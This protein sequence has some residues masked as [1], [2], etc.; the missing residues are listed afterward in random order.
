LKYREIGIS[1]YCII[2]KNTKNTT[3]QLSK[4]NKQIRHKHTVDIRHKNKAMKQ[5]WQQ[6]KTEYFADLYF[7]KHSTKPNDSEL[8]EY[9]NQHEAED[10][11]PH[12]LDIENALYD[13]L[14]QIAIQ[15]QT[16]TPQRAAEIITSAEF[17]V[18]KDI[19][20]MLNN[21]TT[22]EPVNEQPE[23]VIEQTP[24][25][26]EEQTEQENT[27][28]TMS[29]IT[30][31][32]KQ[33]GFNIQ[34]KPKDLPI[35]DNNYYTWATLPN[36][37]KKYKPAPVTKDIISMIAPF[38]SND[39][40]RPALTGIYHDAEAQAMVATNSL[41][42]VYH[43]TK[44]A[45]E[46]ENKIIGIK[47]EVINAQ[48]PLYKSLVDE[49]FITDSYSYEIDIRILKTFVTAISQMLDKKDFFVKVAISKRYAV[50]DIDCLL[51]VINYWEQQKETKLFVYHKGNDSGMFVFA[52]QKLKTVE[53]LFDNSWVIIMPHIAETDHFQF[54]N[55]FA[56]IRSYFDFVSNSIV[57]SDKNDNFY[58]EKYIAAETDKQHNITIKQIKALKKL[59]PKKPTLPIIEEVYVDGNG[60]LA[61]TD[62]TT[63]TVITK[64]GF[65]R[66][67]YGFGADAL[68]STYSDANDFTQTGFGD[69]T[70]IAEITDTD[71]TAK[72]EDVSKNI[73]KENYTNYDKIILVAEKGS[74]ITILATN[75]D[76]FTI[77]KI[78]A[79][80][81]EDDNIYIE[82]STNVTT[83][84]KNFDAG[85]NIAIR[86][87]NRRV[88]LSC[89]AFEI[90]TPYYSFANNRNVVYRYRNSL[91]PTIK[92]SFDSTKLIETAK[93]HKADGKNAYDIRLFEYLS[94][95]ITNDDLYVF[96]T[97][98]DKPD[99]LIIIPIKTGTNV[100]FEDN[101]GYFLLSFT[102]SK[103]ENILNLPKGDIDLILDQNLNCA[104]I[105]PTK[106]IFGKKA[107]K[108][109]VE[110]IEPEPVAPEPTPEPDTTLFEKK[111]KR[112]K[113]EAKQE[114][115]P[116]PELTA[117][118]R[119][120]KKAAEIKARKAKEAA[121]AEAK[122]KQEPT[123][124][125]E[126]TAIE[127]LYKKA[128]EIKARKA[129]EATEAEAKA[130]Q[131]PTP[132]R[133]L[134]AIERLYKKAAEIKA[135]KAKEATQAPK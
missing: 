130:K 20:E 15:K 43:K 135:R 108:P 40:R 68:I 32:G 12:Y 102:K 5:L 45:K 57:S 49:N 64:T 48:F 16:M 97:D 53:Q 95:R 88:C 90:Y 78:K 82:G 56:Y 23:N 9:I 89:A 63:Y 60:N 14:Y 98:N 100:D 62:L 70:L 99:P 115:T 47:G 126:L 4:H 35:G 24:E 84:L 94:I 22:E 28:T 19:L 27:T 73:G 85:G 7:A 44:I 77:R 91:N 113:A 93:K 37:L 50:F 117:I 1:A 30:I 122:A 61:I 26:I 8:V 13:S 11:T 10:V 125:P 46:N 74:Q 92:I 75:G 128:A 127:R 51:S 110:D 54:V 67:M 101:D 87:D 29:H 81:Y 106:K 71:F 83:V 132:E 52:A 104:F 114:P 111:N 6:T 2:A 66:G 116:E 134:T 79:K 18:P 112:K 59:K 72:F 33:S 25:P 65:E 17:D 120:Y 129:K 76:S 96:S 42:L 80:V 118:E 107:V 131:E 123:P 55:S 86:K 105:R 41:I 124:E 58:H 121:E 109:I 3:K 133:E 39:E 34:K 38:V 31:S 103:T 119:L 69:S 21:T 36:A